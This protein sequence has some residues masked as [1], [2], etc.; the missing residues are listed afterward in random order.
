MT[1]IQPNHSV[2]LFTSSSHPKSLELEA[3]LKS[4]VNELTTF[5]HS[6]IK[7]VPLVSGKDG[8]ISFA[9]ENGHSF[10]FLEQSIKLLKPSGYII[11]YE[12]LKGRQS[13]SS[14]VLARN[15]QF[16]GFLNNVISQSEDYIEVT[17]TKPEWEIGASQ[18]IKL[19]SKKSTSNNN[20]NN[21]ISTW[22]ASK[23]N[24][25]LI[26]DDDLLDETDRLSRP[27][28]KRDDCEVGKSRKACKNCVCG[29]AEEEAAAALAAPKKKLTL[30]MI[31]NPTAFSNCGSC[32]LG[33][34]FRCGGCPYRGLPSFKVGEKISIPASFL[35][36]DI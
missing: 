11:L 23:D 31:E 4:K 16:A 9:D 13:S 29:R 24:D 20:N 18:S 3:S 26:N 27:K 22:S 28:T 15:L 14:E 19:G 35:E 25:E 36:D 30:E 32:G 34:A 5:S 2:L 7:D 33:D 1:I 10:E 12:P 17:A 6:D 21:N 8:I